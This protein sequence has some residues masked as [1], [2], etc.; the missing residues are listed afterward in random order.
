[1]KAKRKIIT[2]KIVRELLDYNPLTGKLFWKKRSLEWFG[3]KTEKQ[4]QHLYKTWNKKF[5]GKRAFAVIEDHGLGPRYKGNILCSKERS[6]SFYTS[7]IVWLWMT[8]TWPK[9]EVDHKNRNAT[10]DR[11]NNLRDVP[12]TINGRN[13]SLRKDNTSGV[14]GVRKTRYGTFEAYLAIDRVWTQIGTFST[15][16]AAIAA[17]RKAAC[18]NGFWGDLKKAGEYTSDKWF[19][20]K[21]VA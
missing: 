20:E 16:E 7:N 18:R 19:H 5:A 10:D 12:A 13:R 11:W 6:L 1:M 15:L 3:G 17:R 8:G 9:G 14:Q 21:R 2:A 4:R